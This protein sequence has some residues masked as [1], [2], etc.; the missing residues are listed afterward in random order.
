MNADPPQI[1]A[2]MHTTYRGLAVKGRGDGTRGLGEGVPGFG[3]LQ[4]W[5][6]PGCGGFGGLGLGLGAGGDAVHHSG[7]CPL[8]GCR[9]VE[10]PGL[11]DRSPP[12]HPGPRPPNTLHAPHSHRLPAHGDESLVSRPPPFSPR[13]VRTLS[14]AN[15]NIF[16]P[17]SEEGGAT[18]LFLPGNSGCH[19]Q[20]SETPCTRGGLSWWTSSRLATAQP[21]RSSV[22][23]AQRVRLGLPSHHLGLHPRLRPR[24][25]AREVERLCNSS[26]SDSSSSPCSSSST[27]FAFGFTALAD[28]LAAKGCG[29]GNGRGGCWGRETGL[30]LGLGLGQGR[31]LWLGLSLSRSL[32]HHLGEQ[33]RG[34]ALLKQKA[35]PRSSDVLGNCSSGALAT[36]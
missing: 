3:G 8:V 12:R 26:R 16:T 4:L 24:C 15:S 1:N 11:H 28:F 31:C 33:L 36:F 20:A 2:K 5:G 25:G 22:R 14:S 35:Q 10:P 19:H 17:F 32:A 13:G 7:I 21:S 27:A 9:R 18:A 6:S 23:G 29:V 30:G 34:A